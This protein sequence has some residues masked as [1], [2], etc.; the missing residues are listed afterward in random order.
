M[1][2]TFIMTFTLHNDCEIANMLRSPWTLL[3]PCKQY[4][5]RSKPDFMHWISNY[6]PWFN[7]KPLRSLISLLLV[8]AL[9]HRRLC[10]RYPVVVV[11]WITNKWRW[12]RHLCF[13][14]DSFRRSGVQRPFWSSHISKEGELWRRCDP[15]CTSQNWLPGKWPGS[16]ENVIPLRQE[17][18][19]N[20]VQP[21][22]SK[23]NRRF[24]FFRK[25]KNWPR[26]PQPW[27]CHQNNFRGQ[28]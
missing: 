15:P 12:A 11:K 7:W 26:H 6:D 13:G 9:V 8:V 19:L 3:S 28:M 22:G 24:Q 16:G 17:C 4:S 1:Y 2:S 23:V 5:I 14:F 18:R 10:Y 20:Y 25:D 21:Q 27:Q